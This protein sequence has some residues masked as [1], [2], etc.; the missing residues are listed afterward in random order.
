MILY[1]IYLHGAS[2]SYLAGDQTR[3]EILSDF[4]TQ[5]TTLGKT[6]TDTIKVTPTTASVT[7]GLT[8]QLTDTIKNPL[9]TVVTGAAVTWRSSAPTIATVD[10][11]GLVTGKQPG[12]VTIWATIPGDSA[13]AQITVTGVSL[14]VAP[15][16][17]TLESNQTVQLT[18]TLRDASG[19][20]LTG[21]PVSW[22]SSNPSVSTVSATG[23]VTGGL[24][25]GSAII[26][27]SSDGQTGSA[28]ITV[29]AGDLTVSATTTGSSLSTGY[30][31]TVDGSFNHSIGVN[32]SVTF[33][34]VAAGK[35]T[36]ALSGVP[37]NCS[38]STANPQTV[39]V[40]GGGTVSVLFP[41]ACAAASG[42]RIRAP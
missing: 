5:I 8:T 7:A 30:T 1:D 22:T 12:V 11:T 20:V 14:T 13:A 31:V 10:G 4:R 32:A 35:H 17:A 37:S 25:A 29:P 42:V 19:N 2:E 34:Y 28:S 40:L 6:C 21:L 9:G 36:V 33:A 16:F 27:A 24:V 3:A 41:V 26:T 39:T 23:L 15:A 38:V 18:A